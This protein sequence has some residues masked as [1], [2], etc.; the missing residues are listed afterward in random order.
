[1]EFVQKESNR[2]NCPQQLCSIVKWYLKKNSQETTGTTIE[3][4]QNVWNKASRK[5]AQAIVQNL[6]ES[7]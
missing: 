2:P 5:L 4:F 6:M 1:M 3:D 7:I